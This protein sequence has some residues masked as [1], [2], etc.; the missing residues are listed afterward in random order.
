MILWKNYQKSNENAEE[1]ASGLVSASLV[2]MILQL[3]TWGCD[4]CVYWDFGCQKDCESTAFKKFC[5]LLQYLYWFFKI[6]PLTY[7]G[8]IQ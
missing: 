6:V 2:K 1:I 5:F 3:A 8:S 7:A 4:G